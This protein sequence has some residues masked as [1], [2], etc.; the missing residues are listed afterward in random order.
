MKA[1]CF[2]RVRKRKTKP[3]Q[4]DTDP[5]LRFFYADYLIN[6]TDE[7]INRRNLTDTSNLKCRCST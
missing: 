6:K 1:N 7:E 4:N 2:N 5:L 3:N